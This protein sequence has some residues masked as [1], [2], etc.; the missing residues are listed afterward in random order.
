VRERELELFRRLLLL[1]RE[2]FFP[3]A[4]PVRL[5]TVAQAIRSAVLVPLPRRLALDSMCEAMRFCLEL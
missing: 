3:L 4:P 2:D 5:F 1:A